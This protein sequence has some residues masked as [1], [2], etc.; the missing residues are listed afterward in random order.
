MTLNRG[1]PFPTKKQK[2]LMKAAN[3]LSWITT[4]FTTLLKKK[5]AKRLRKAAEKGDRNLRP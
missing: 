5:Q 1:N 4:P 3:F 2:A